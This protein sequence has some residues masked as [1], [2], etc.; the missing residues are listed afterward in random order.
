MQ[1]SE[2]IR[3]VDDSQRV[4]PDQRY[5]N[6]GIYSYGR[7][8]FPK[9]P[10]DGAVTSALSLRRVTAG[11]FI[12]SRL[13]AFEGAYGMVT[14]EYDGFFVSGEYPTFECDPSV[15][16]TE[17]LVAYFKAPSVWEEVSIG[18][19]GL[20]HRRQRVQPAQLLHHNIWVPPLAWQDR[21]AKVQAEADQLKRVQAETNG[22]I[23]ALVPALLDRAFKGQL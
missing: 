4:S 17:F 2:C 12:Y 5:P 8:L 14:E 3:L 9:P 15:I 1:L 7:G 20:G 21:L 16:R 6:L 10:I 23:E 22:E 18:S 13:F 19:K 11:Q